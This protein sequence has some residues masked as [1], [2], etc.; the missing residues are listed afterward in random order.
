MA[1][2]GRTLICGSRSCA[3]RLLADIREARTVAGTE[4]RAMVAR[5]Q[6]RPAITLQ[7]TAEVDAATVAEADA[8][9]AAAAAEGTSAE[10]EGE[11]ADT[12]VVVEV[13]DT[14][15][16]AATAAIANARL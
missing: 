15:E 1:A 14:P 9:R 13:V 4:R 12:S 11:A 7:A 8:L 3:I 10:A 16:A 5:I 6:R 2:V